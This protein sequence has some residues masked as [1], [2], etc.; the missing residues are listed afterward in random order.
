MTGGYRLGDVRHVVASPARATASIGF[1]AQ[2]D[3]DVGLKEL[4]HAPLRRPPARAP[5][6]LSS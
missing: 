6:R 4:A 5:D 1:V 2:K 3:P